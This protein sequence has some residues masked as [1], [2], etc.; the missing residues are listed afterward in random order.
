MNILSTVTGPAGKSIKSAYDT[1]SVIADHTGGAIADGNVRGHIIGAVSDVA[2]G[3]LT[4]M[5]TGKV[6]DAAGWAGGKLADKI[7]KALPGQIKQTVAGG[8]DSI[9]NKIFGT[10]NTSY[11]SSLDLGGAT[12]TKTIKSIFGTGDLSGQVRKKIWEAGKDQATDWAKGQ[13]SDQFI[14]QTTGGK[15]EDAD[16]YKKKLSDIA[17]ATIKDKLDSWGRKPKPGVE[18]FR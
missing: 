7:G 5:M 6:G 3:K 12:V 18:R 13:V 1:L 14:K 8:I 4:D 15:I 9:S 11:G 17:Q 2:S 10:G 16:D